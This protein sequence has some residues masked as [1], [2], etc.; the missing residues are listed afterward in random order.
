MTKPSDLDE[1]SDRLWDT[2]LR[3]MQD[4]WANYNYLYVEDPERADKLRR[5]RWGGFFWE[6]R[7]ALMVS[8]IIL[9]I[10]RLTDPPEM[11]KR[12]EPDA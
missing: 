12:P 1:M 4:L 3:E 11:G 5:P 9:S 8:E 7:P 2:E 10:S 6:P